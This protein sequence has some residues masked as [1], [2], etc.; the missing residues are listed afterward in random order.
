MVEDNKNYDYVDRAMDEKSLFEK[1]SNYIPGYRGYAD[2]EKVR[3][4]D[5]LV[6]QNVA[7][8][9]RESYNNISE[10]FDL[11]A[12]GDKNIVTVDKIN[13]K[14]DALEQKISHAESGYSPM[15]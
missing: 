6:R 8:V 2:Q 1:V 7:K 14:L 15:F 13:L 5:I 4:T 10:V 12:T 9:L 11:M 3:N